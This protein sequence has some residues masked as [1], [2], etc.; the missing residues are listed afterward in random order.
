MNGFMAA[1]PAEKSSPWFQKNVAAFLDVCQAHGKAS[2]QHHNMLVERFIK[3]PAEELPE[4]NQDDLTA[5]GPPLPVL[6]A[7]L[8]KFRDQRCAAKRDD[9]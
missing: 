1:L 8:E 4:E 6:L 7:A 2:K 3:Q 5:S 9:I